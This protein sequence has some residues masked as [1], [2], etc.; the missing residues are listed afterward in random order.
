[1]LLQAMVSGERVFGILDKE[2]EEI[3][4]KAGRRSTRDGAR[5]RRAR[6]KTCT[7]AYNERRAGPSA[8]SAFEVP[9]RARTLAIV[10]PT[11]AGKSSILNLVSRFYDV[12]LRRPCSIDGTRR[13][14]LRISAPFD[15]RIAIVLQDVFLFRGSLLDNIRLFDERITRAR[16]EDAVRAVNAE[17]VISRLPR[18]LDS[19]VEE[20]GANFSA[21]ERQLLAFARA[22]VHDPAIL[23]LDEATSS[24]DT[25]TEQLIQEALET[26]RK[27]R[28]T[29][30]VAHRLS[31]IKSADQILVMQ[32]GRVK[33]RGTHED[34]LRENGLYRKM[35]ELQVRQHAD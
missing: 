32:R 15:A 35:Y 20:R 10:G 34:L 13:A 24:I 7:S 1:M 23:V 29:I 2:P 3:V 25:E 9:A 11:G 27:G 18:G 26:M 30:V 6:S 16:V 17:G 31:T 22:L 21:G 19:P 14:R 33:E 28:T 12:Q 8:A 5:R 4:D